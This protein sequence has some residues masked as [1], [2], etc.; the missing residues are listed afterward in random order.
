[1]CVFLP[2]LPSLFS[3]H[4][5]LSIAFVIFPPPSSSKQGHLF[6]IRHPLR[7]LL[8]FLTQF[9]EFY[10]VSAAAVDFSLRPLRWPRA[11]GR[12]AKNQCPLSPLSLIKYGGGSVVQ[13]PPPPI[14]PK[15]VGKDGKEGERRKGPP[16]FS[17]PGTDF[18]R[19]RRR[20]AGKHVRG[21]GDVV[22][23]RTNSPHSHPSTQKFTFRRLYNFTFHLLSYWKTRIFFSVEKCS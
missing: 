18:S 2:H 12:G 21:G 17:L 1:M 5:S 13:G 4:G 14:L 6:S 22:G 19:T 3:I 10:D 9:S 8:L 16:S 20:E 23:E 11:F 7:S 15:T